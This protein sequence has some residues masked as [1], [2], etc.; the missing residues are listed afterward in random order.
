MPERPLV[1]LHLIQTDGITKSVKAADPDVFLPV[2]AQIVQ[3]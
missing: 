2:T 1:F 3:L